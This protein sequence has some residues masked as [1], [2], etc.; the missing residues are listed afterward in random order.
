MRA[1]V[2]T[3]PGEGHV[4][5]VP[6]LEPANGEVVVALEA[7][8]LCGT[9]REL[10]EGT[11]P[12]LVDGLT[13]YPFT[14]GHEWAGTV[15]A[16]GAGATTPIGTRVTGDVFISCGQCPDCVAGRINTCPTRYEIGVLG[17]WPGAVAEQIRIPERVLYEIPD[18]VSFESAIFAEPGVTSLH[19]IERC[20]LAPNE[21]CLVVGSGTLGIL[22]IQ[23]ALAMGAIVDCCSSSASGRA[24]A[25]SAGAREVFGPQNVRPAYDVV[26]EASGQPG[27]L[28]S[29]L[30]STRAGGRL[31]LIGICKD[32]SWIDANAVVLHD[33]SVHGVIGG[34]GRFPRLLQLIASGAI[35]TEALVGSRIG[36]DSVEAALRND[37]RPGAP[38]KTVVVR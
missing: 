2:I 35:E 29:A 26:I 11:M 17:N 31:G 14:P 20:S 8:G 21:T 23:I 37:P 24:R 12:Y 5:E 22:A 3:G 28:A 18:G 10:F 30:E 33:L 19:A 9:D 34:P 27:A 25:L 38:P 13:R 1:F 4:E 32:P 16:L 36:I 7:T 15:V 6:D